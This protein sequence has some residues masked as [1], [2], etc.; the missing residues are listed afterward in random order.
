M[1][2][3]LCKVS[4]APQ[5]NDLLI[6]RYTDPRGGSTHVMHRFTPDP[7]TGDLKRLRDVLR[8][9][10]T[11]INDKW[12]KDFFSATFKE[13]STLRFAVQ[14]AVSHVTFHG[15]VEGSDGMTVEIDEV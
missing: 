6:V 10:A 15:E 13:P 3:V 9:F 5:P 14:D 11:E 8:D 7:K 12:M 4:G 2:V 1:K